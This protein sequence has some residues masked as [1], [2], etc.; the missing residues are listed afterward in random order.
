[1][2]S[3]NRLMRFPILGIL[4]L[5]LTVL[6]LGGCMETEEEHTPTPTLIPAVEPTCTT[7]G[8]I[9]Y[10][11]CGGCQL[12]YADEDCT[13]VITRQEVSSLPRV[14][15]TTFRL[16]DTSPPRDTPTYASA[17]QRARW[18][19]TLQ[20]LRPPPRRPSTVW[21]AAS[22]WL[23]LSITC[24]TSI[25]CAMMPPSTG[26]SV[27]AARSRRAPCLLISE[28]APPA[29]SLEC[30]RYATPLMAPP[31]VIATRNA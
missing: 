8:N 27:N 15:P 11:A 22:C 12:L 13:T 17:E 2:S 7:P 19:P 25:S 28:D 1:M 9:A 24:I 31:P 14:I 6:G 21:I 18:C 16:G 20:A 30:A 10:Y 29:W 3:R 4:V 23:P 26:T 5:L